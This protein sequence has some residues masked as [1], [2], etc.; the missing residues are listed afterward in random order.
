MTFYDTYTLAGRKGLNFITMSLTQMGVPCV[1]VMIYYWFTFCVCL[2][3]EDACN[4]EIVE[5]RAVVYELGLHE[6]RVDI[7]PLI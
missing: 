4:R 3:I 2:T 5:K 7:Y 1:I 6:S